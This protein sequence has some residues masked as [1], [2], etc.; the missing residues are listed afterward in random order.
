M[1]KCPKC[2]EKIEDQFESCWKCANK[3]VEIQPGGG[4]DYKALGLL[5]STT[6]YIEGRE[7]AATLDIVCGEAIMGANVLRDLVA[8]ITDIIGGR[9][10]VYETKLREARMVALYEMV[11]EARTLGADAVVGVDLDYE[12]V[13]QSM[14]MVTASGT[15]ITLKH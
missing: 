5:V 2:G 4:V 15:A 12:T 10:G 9:S 3:G 14:L 11:V 6:P 1:W 13:G 8:G 7:S